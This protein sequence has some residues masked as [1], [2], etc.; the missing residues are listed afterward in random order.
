MY[1]L[2][3][4]GIF[5]NFIQHR[6]SRGYMGTWGYKGRI[7]GRTGVWVHEGTRVHG[8]KVRARIK[9]N[10]YMGLIFFDPFTVIQ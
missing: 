1:L 5:V 4:N 8:Y 6:S 2:V 3:W 9:Y 7:T 10:E